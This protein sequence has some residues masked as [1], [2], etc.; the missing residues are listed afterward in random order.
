MSIGFLERSRTERNVLKIVNGFTGSPLLNGLTESAILRWDSGAADIIPAPQRNKVKSLLLEIS[1][2]L[3][4]NSDASK[5]IFAG[6]KL[7]LNG[8]TDMCIKELSKLL[9]K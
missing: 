3:R 8:T 2:R 7:I 6:E 4:S 1:Q 5:H 9:S